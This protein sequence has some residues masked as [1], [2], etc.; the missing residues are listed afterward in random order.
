MNAGPIRAVRRGEDGFTLVETMTAAVVL[1][2]AIVLAMTPIVVSMRAIDHAKEID[3]AENLAQARIEE[4]RSLDYEDVGNPGFAPDGVLER[5]LTKT[6]GGRSYTIDTE[7]R[8]VG[9]ATGL[10]IVPQGGD[11]VEGRFDPGVNYKLVTV[12]VTA[13]SGRIPPVEMETI[14]A[15]PTVGALDDVAIVTVT[16]DRHEPYDPSTAADPILRLV[17]AQ[18]YL[19]HDTGSQ[20]V[21]PDVAVGSYTIEFF[22]ANG[23]SMHPETI[24]SG[25]NEVDAVAGWNATRTIR[26]YEPVSLTVDV[27]DED[28][29]PVPNAT[30]TITDLADGR[31]VT[32]PAGDY[33][34]T[35]LVPDRYAV[36]GTAPGY[37]G[38]AVEVDVPGYGGGSTATATLVMRAHTV[39]TTAVTF[40]VDYAGWATW[41]THGAKVT[42][43]HPVLGSWS[44]TTDEW[45]EVTL[46]LPTNESGFQVVAETEWGHAPAATT[47]ATGTGPQ[48]EYLSLGKPPQ[49]DRFAIYDGP[50]GPG[51]FYRYWVET[52]RNGQ[53]QWSQS[54]LLESNALGKATFIVPEANNRRVHIRAYCPG[55]I[56]LDRRTFTMTGWN[57]SWNPSGSCP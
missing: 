2:V 9:A 45:G 28:G 54:T 48:S 41:F 43:T 57:R 21:F 30:V 10:D 47:I 49:T 14:V 46:Q 8:Y 37:L 34:F 26:I 55:G 6:V 7:V 13:D 22:D 25:A 31:T 24:S 35:D 32:N 27:V 15:P 16:I 23:W 29:D 33:V 3:V 56:E 39:T 52:W 36:T 11:G 18:S 38:D 1:V 12:E 17:G 40:R 44:G 4:A 53:W 19:P 5:T 50:V 51:G 42:V 20:Q